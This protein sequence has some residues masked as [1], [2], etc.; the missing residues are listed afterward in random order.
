LIRRAGIEIAPIR[1]WRKKIPKKDVINCVS[2]G[3]NL[4]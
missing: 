1:A 3:T 2:D 4:R